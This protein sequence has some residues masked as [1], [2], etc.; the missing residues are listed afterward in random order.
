[1]ETAMTVAR[2]LAILNDLRTT[3]DQLSMLATLAD[4]QRGFV[5]A[6]DANYRTRRAQFQAQ[7]QTAQGELI[8]GNQLDEVAAAAVQTLQA[9]DASSRA[10][11][12][13][14]MT[15]GNLAAVER[16]LTPAQNA[17]IDWQIPLRLQTA[18]ALPIETADAKRIAAAMMVAE[19]FLNDV[20][21]V[22]IDIYLATRTDKIETYLRRYVDPRSRDW[23]GLR[24]YLFD[25]TDQAKLVPEQRWNAATPVFAARIL[26]TLGIAQPPEERANRNRR[27]DWDTMY[28]LFSFPKTGDLMRHMVDLRQQPPK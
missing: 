14:P 8:A 26:R 4:R 3:V 25:I 23:P 24:Q 27:Y 15:F 2:H 28:E 10:K 12:L 11:D 13:E 19:D 6:Y 18:P 17:L 9:G 20:R 16:A 7:L 1:M 5:R 22:P 21:Y